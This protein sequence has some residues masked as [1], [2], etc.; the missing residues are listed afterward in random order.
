MEV[1][2]ISTETFITIEGAFNKTSRATNEAALRRYE[3]PIS[4]KLAETHRKTMERQDCKLVGCANILMI[5]IGWQILII[6]HN[7]SSL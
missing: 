4:E 7:G 2:G 3:V 6:I 5:S 1:E